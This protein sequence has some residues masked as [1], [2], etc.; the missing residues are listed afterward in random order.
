[1]LTRQSP[2][3]TPSFLAQKRELKNTSANSQ[4]LRL[5]DKSNQD[6]PGQNKRTRAPGEGGIQRRRDHGSETEGAGVHEGM[7]GQGG[8]PSSL[9]SNPLTPTRHTDTH[10]HHTHATTR[11]KLKETR[12]VQTMYRKC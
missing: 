11:I 3:G 7:D 1:M 6:P 8:L 4:Q 10:P 2:D 12:S 5:Q 9:G